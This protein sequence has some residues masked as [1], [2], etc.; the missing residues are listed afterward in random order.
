MTVCHLAPFKQI[1]IQLHFKPPQWMTNTMNAGCTHQPIP[2]FAHKERKKCKNE[3]QLCVP[4]GS[5]SNSYKFSFISTPSSEW[6][7]Q[8]QWWIHTL[9]NPPICTKT[10]MIQWNKDYKCVKP[11]RE[12]L[13]PPIYSCIRFC[14]VF[15]WRSTTRY[16]LRR[17]FKM[18]IFFFLSQRNTFLH[19]DMRTW[20]RCT[21]QPG[22]I[23]KASD[24]IHD[25][26]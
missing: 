25:M 2:P 20:Y 8:K 13:P 7:T 11:T 9:A 24:V 23:Y 6:Q 14:F 3:R 5:L 21:H 10:T 17:N 19:K 16:N 12:H 26:Q 1:Q 4:F 22:L 18:T 15:F